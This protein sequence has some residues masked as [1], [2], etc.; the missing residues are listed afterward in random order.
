MS[1]DSE[2]SSLVR[3]YRLFG[4]LWLENPEEHLDLEDLA[5]LKRLEPL[6]RQLEHTPK[7]NCPASPGTQSE[8][9]REFAEFTERE[10]A[11]WKHL[12]ADRPREFLLHPSGDLKSALACHLHNPTFYVKDPYCRDMENMSSPT[13]QQLNQAGF[14]S[15]NCFFFDHICRRDRTDDVLLFYTE[16]IIR[17]HEVF[18][19]SIRKA[20]AAKVEICWGKHVRERMKR[21]LKLTSL[22]LWG[23]FKDVELFLEMEDQI[24]RRFVLFVAHP[25]FFFYHGSFTESGLKF[26]E[27]Q[28]RRQDLYLAVASKLSAVPLTESFYEK[29]HRPALYG[30]FDKVSRSLVMQL[31]TDADAQLSAAF[32]ARYEEVES[33]SRM[34]LETLKTEK[35]NIN[36]V[37]LRLPVIS[38]RIQGDSQEE[39][40]RRR[41]QF[42]SM[43]ETLTET[44]GKCFGGAVSLRS[45]TQANWMS[46]LVSEWDEISE[47]AQVPGLLASWIQNQ[48]G[49]KIDQKPISSN[50]ELFAAY[51]FLSPAESNPADITLMQ[52]VLRVAVLYI[53]RVKKQRHSSVQDLIIP[54]SRPYNIMRRKCA[55]CGK[56]VLDDAFACFAKADARKYVI[57]YRM[58]GCGAEDCCPAGKGFANLVPLDAHQ[59]YRMATRQALQCLRTA[60]WE[61]FLLR[62]SPEETL[63]VRQK[64][65]TICKICRVQSFTDTKPRWTSEYPSRYVTPVRNC[66]NCS[67]RY[68]TFVPIDAE[69]LTITK[70][71]L[72][73][74]WR[75][76][77]AGGI[78]PANYPRRPDILWSNKSHITKLQELE[79]AREISF[80]TSE[81]SAQSPQ[82]KSF[83]KFNNKNRL[84]C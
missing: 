12:G 27:T 9:D 36:D 15:R 77:K 32:T 14:S 7:S 28:A 60:G 66:K 5:R 4:N 69:I 2:N 56:R 51:R 17:V 50:E 33:S 49:L 57:W 73:K 76:L 75:D 25:Q 81:K 64:V 47:W 23:E 80:A 19:L 22:K 71:A 43:G 70:A 84:K 13:M 8:M 30:Q 59:S 18:V 16:D 34:I 21:L 37:R 78:E 35:Q 62:C 67:K 65:V 55:K 20:M 79:Y 26:R 40:L 46:M 6:I 48:A 3:T 11:A 1:T 53:A 41:K 72:S 63:E 54:G 58:Y 24:I 31:E 74:K 83:R 38:K 44:L 10:I 68:C 45:V 42:L 82:L 39:L 52:A 61:E 29:A